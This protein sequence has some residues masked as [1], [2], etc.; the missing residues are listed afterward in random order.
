MS[1]STTTSL[2]L[3]PATPSPWRL[4]LVL[5]A[6]GLAAGQLAAEEPPGIAHPLDPLSKE[7]L[8]EAVR[9]LKAEGKAGP[10][11]RFPL[12]ALEEPPK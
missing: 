5:A 9:V 7:E 6:F 10:T 8:A 2:V 12:I 1:F 3:G 11:A 4:A